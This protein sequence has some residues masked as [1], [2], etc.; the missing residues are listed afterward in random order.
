ICGYYTKQ[1]NT[2]DDT[3][4]IKFS[5]KHQKGDTQ[6]IMEAESGGKG[7]KEYLEKFSDEINLNINP[8]LAQKLKNL[9]EKR[10]QEKDSPK[11]ASHILIDNQTLQRN[12]SL[13]DF[14]L[15]FKPCLT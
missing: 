4:W 11:I 8:N 3:D 7:A 9:K 13:L 5:Q 2:R 1:D 6:S 14:S 15:H 10:Y 12:Q